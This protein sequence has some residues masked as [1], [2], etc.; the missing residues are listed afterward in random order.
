MKIVKHKIKP[1]SFGVITARQEN[2]NRFAEIIS[3]GKFKDIFLP[4]FIVSEKSNI[5][6]DR[7][8]IFEE[9]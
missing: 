9:E 6:E 8:D 5:E 4:F 7:L 1:G 3:K 2:M